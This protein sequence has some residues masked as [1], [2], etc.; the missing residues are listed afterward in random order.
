VTRFKETD[1][2][3][4]DR[5]SIEKVVDNGNLHTLVQVFLREF[6]GL[7]PTQVEINDWETVYQPGRQVYINN[8]GKP[9]G[10]HLDNGSSETLT[11]PTEISPIGGSETMSPI[12]DYSY[13]TYQQ[14]HG[15]N[16]TY[17]TTNT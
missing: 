2:C 14:H 3:P 8:T 9:F 16:A 13:S 15:S 6:P 7:K 5:K 11:S 10:F 4:A 17:S 12:T 1:K